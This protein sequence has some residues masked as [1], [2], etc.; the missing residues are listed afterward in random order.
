MLHNGTF[1]N[2]GHGTLAATEAICGLHETGG[3]ATDGLVN[4]KDQPVVDDFPFPHDFSVYLFVNIGC[5]RVFHKT[6][7]KFHSIE[8][9]YRVLSN[10][11]KSHGNPS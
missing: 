3:A 11:M 9:L 8:S 10:P 4:V 1:A 2:S 5:P 6:P 7:F